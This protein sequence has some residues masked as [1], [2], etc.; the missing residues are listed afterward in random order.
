M[1]ESGSARRDSRKKRGGSIPGAKGQPAFTL[2]LPER[3]PVP[4]LIAVPH[5][6]RTYPAELAELMRNHSAASLRL[7]DRFADFVAQAVAR[8]TGAGLL[9]AHAPRAMIDLNRASI[10]KPKLC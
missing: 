9:V 4:V 6:G 5:A 8:E 10:S 2:L 1:A 3:A 7:E